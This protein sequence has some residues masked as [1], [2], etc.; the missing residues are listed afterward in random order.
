[1]T[2]TDQDPWP[3]SPQGCLSVVWPPVRL[4]RGED[5]SHGRNSYQ[6]QIS[7]S[8]AQS[9]NSGGSQGLITDRCSAEMF[10]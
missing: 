3:L 5:T 2:P 9:I 7:F 4:Q 10:L 8:K 6:S 1:M